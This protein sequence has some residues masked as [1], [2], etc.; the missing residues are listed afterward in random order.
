MPRPAVRLLHARLPHDGRGVPRGE[1]RPDRGRGPRGRLRQPVPLHRLPEH[2]RGGP[3]RRRARPREG[4]R[5]RD[6]EA[7][8]RAGA[9][10]EDRS[11]SPAGRFLDDLGQDALGVAFVRSPHAHARVVDIDATGALEVD[12]LVAVYTYD[13]LVAADGRR[14]PVARAAAAA[15]PASVAARAPHRLPA[16]PRRGQPRR[17][18][19]GHGGRRR[20]VPRRGRR[21]AGAG[22]LRVL[23]PVVGVEAARRA[24]RGCT[25]TCPTTSPPTSSRRSAT[26]TPRWPP[27]RTS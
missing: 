24:D 1:P 11:C 3:A 8:R 18:A 15:H 13:D 14:Q 12:G 23:P 4:G 10:V 26:S 21:R 6:D 17:R 2:R 25:T 20:P 22:H 16:G 9:A 19:G 7:V 27:R 5:L